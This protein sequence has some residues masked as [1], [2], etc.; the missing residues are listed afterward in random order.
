VR[1][2]SLAN[3]SETRRL[4]GALFKIMA[5]VDMVHVPYRINNIPDLITGQVQIVFAPIPT[6]VGFIRAGKLHSLAV[7]NATASGVSGTTW[8]ASPFMRPRG[9]SQSPSP[10]SRSCP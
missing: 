7:T 2:I 4:I 6:V 10:R 3:R 5:G 9:I 8:D 1:N